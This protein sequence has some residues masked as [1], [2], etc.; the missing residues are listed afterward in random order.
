[1]STVADII[2]APHETTAPAARAVKRDTLTISL[3]FLLGLS[4]VQ[5]IVTFVR[6]TLFCRFLD[7][8][9]L[10]A[11]DMALSFV[12]LTATLVVLGIP[13]S[14][15]RYVEHYAQR[16]QLA[17]FIRRTVWTCTG[18]GLI[19]MVTVALAAQQFSRLIFGT[20][21]N[22]DLVYGVAGCL[23]ATI[24][25]GLM[26]ELLTAMRM[27]RVVSGLQLIKGV[28]FTATG[29]ALLLLWKSGPISLILGHS[30]AC[31]AAAAVSLI[32]LLP[33]W[34]A[35]HG[36]AVVEQAETVTH[37]ALWAKLMPFAIWIWTANILSHIFEIIDRYMIVHCG[38][39]S[40]E[41]ALT[42]VGHYHSSRI[43]PLMFVAFAG[44]LSGLIIPHMSRDWESG[45]RDAVSKKLNMAMKLFGL[46]LSVGATGVLIVAPMLFEI[47]FGGKYD[48]GLAVLPWTLVYCC[49]F[50]LS[51][52]AE[53]Y[54]C[55][56]ERMRWV[57][58]AVLVGLVVN[59]VLNFIL[60][61]YFGL[62]GAVLATAAAKFILLI[63]IC[64]FNRRLGMDL[65]H[66]TW[67]VLALPVVVCF[68]VIPALTI[69]TLV[70]LAIIS[71]DLI[72]STEEKDQLKELALD[73][74]RRRQGTGLAAEQSG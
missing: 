50:G 43:V 47:G 68:G 9:Q 74:W 52:V 64:G 72:L 65:H 21:E 42:E 12:L 45:Q 73:F 61:P 38:S 31:I 54:L 4:L 26:T 24:V 5:P 39:L 60:L 22:V 25:F 58:L 57:S 56:Q 23:G 11:W 35:L 44:L 67:F 51:F 28:V 46:V 34:R 55:C 33:A 49:W 8:T 53:V 41:Q 30:V 2:D 10:G 3:V 59:V 29:V 16:G 69:L 17:M 18:L 36:A 19:A 63:L 48:G 14:Y 7:P 70:M 20:A 62:M 27:F 1:M 71:S 37:R 66:G 13:G 40:S 32:W 6:G 15:G